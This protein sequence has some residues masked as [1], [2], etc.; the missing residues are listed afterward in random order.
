[1]GMV[2]AMWYID[3]RLPTV[4]GPLQI[5]SHREHTDNEDDEMTGEFYISR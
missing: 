2:G 5:F 3:R 4:S 1:M